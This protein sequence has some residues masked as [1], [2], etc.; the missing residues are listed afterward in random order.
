MPHLT[1]LEPND[2]DAWQPLWQGYL[3]FYEEDLAP[4]VTDDVFGRLAAADGDLHG[5]LARRDDGTAAGFVHWQAHPSTW[6]RGSYCYLEDLYVD[7]E[8]RGSGI[9][10]ALI[11]HVRAW[12][13]AQGCDKVYW[14][15]AQG[16]ATARGLYDT[17]ATLTGVV[18]YEIPLETR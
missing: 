15:T 17:V 9:G 4:E 8:Q 3:E 12:A 10:R 13:E 14:I 5:V 11:A 7:P 6:T 2:R 1:P 18:Q 16:N